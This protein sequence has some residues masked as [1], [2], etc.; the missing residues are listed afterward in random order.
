MT[1]IIISLIVISCSTYIIKVMAELLTDF[2]EIRIREKK[3]LWSFI[4]H[5]ILGY[6][7]LIIYIYLGNHFA[8]ISIFFHEVG[9]LLT[10]I[11]FKAEVVGVFLSPFEGKTFINVENLLDIQLTIV[12]LA[13]GLGVILIGIILLLL[14]HWNKE[15]AFVIHF[16]LSLIVLM[17]VCSDLW[18]FFS[19]AMTLS[20]DMG[21]I[22]LLNPNLNPK[23]IAY[24]CLLGFI[25]V[26]VFGIWSIMKRGKYFID[27]F[28]DK[29]LVEA[30]NL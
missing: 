23:A 27:S 4:A 17:A 22:I 3:K 15:L 6:I 10:A 2:I 28:N 8:H 19:G 25:M 14:L 24:I 29:P 12:T 13:G 30:A 18:Y 20:N 11:S 16:P 5:F 26:I 9:H 7:L 1:K 21:Q